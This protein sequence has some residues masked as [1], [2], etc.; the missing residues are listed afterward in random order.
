MKEPLANWAHRV[1][2]AVK[3]SIAPPP[4]GLGSVGDRCDVVLDGGAGAGDPETGGR[5][6]GKSR[7]LGSHRVTSFR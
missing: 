7:G 3:R 6:P 5:A 2:A 4:N 1:L